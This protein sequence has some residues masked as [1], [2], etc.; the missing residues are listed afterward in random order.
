MPANQ[1]LG[2]R[3][4]TKI[5]TAIREIDVS[6]GT[7]ILTRLQPSTPAEQESSPEAKV[8]TIT[9]GP[10]ESKTFDPAQ[11]GFDVYSPEGAR[12]YRTYETDPVGTEED[13]RQPGRAK[14]RS[15]RSRQKRSS[16]SRGPAAA[17]TSRASKESASTS[18]KASASGSP[19]K[20]SSRGSKSASS[21]SGARKQSS[22]KSRGKRS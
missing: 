21:N 10:G 5:E 1:S 18:G 22:T 19:K 11:S 12:F 8:E 2:V 7:V 13:R 14:T 4:N 20:K 3:A 15:S 17:K 6:A 9:L 16:A